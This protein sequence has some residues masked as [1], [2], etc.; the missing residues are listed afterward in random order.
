MSL[1][2]SSHSS[3]YIPFSKMV[4]PRFLSVGF[5]MIFLLD[6]ILFKILSSELSKVLFGGSNFNFKFSIFESSSK[7]LFL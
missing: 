2:W 3:L 5:M 6:L 1:R 7:F 4:I